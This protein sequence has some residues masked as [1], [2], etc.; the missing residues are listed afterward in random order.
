MVVSGSD[1]LARGWGVDSVVE[2]PGVTVNC[3]G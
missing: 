2:R 1:G 3:N